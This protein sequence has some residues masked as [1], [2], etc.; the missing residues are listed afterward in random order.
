[1]KIPPTRTSEKHTMKVDEMI[2]QLGL[3]KITLLKNNPNTYKVS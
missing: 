2:L 1:M 3:P